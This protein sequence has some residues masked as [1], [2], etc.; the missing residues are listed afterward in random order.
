MR[1]DRSSIVWR[2]LSP[3]YP[4][5][6]RGT[7]CSLSGSCPCIAE[8]SWAFRSR[9]PA[10]PAVRPALHLGAHAVSPAR[11]QRVETPSPP[12]GLGG[13]PFRSARVPLGASRRELRRN[14]PCA[15]LEEVAQNLGPV[16]HAA[17]VGMRERRGVPRA[18]EQIDG[19][20]GL[21]D[22]VGVLV[23]VLDEGMGRGAERVLVVVEVE[24]IIGQ[25]P[26]AGPVLGA[27]FGLRGTAGGPPRLPTGS[28]VVPSRLRRRICPAGTRPRR[29]RPDRDLWPAP[30]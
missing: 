23:A 30:C 6:R 14:D 2:V 27:G 15:V 16:L 28:G 11:V 20:A 7:R 10:D 17:D 22:Q 26:G 4:D 25:A 19:G 24:L 8:R 18:C 9:G 1:I 12:R 5:V 21:G 13:S 29:A 3:S